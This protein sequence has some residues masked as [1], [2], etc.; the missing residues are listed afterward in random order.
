MLMSLPMVGNG[1][2]LQ[3]DIS[4]NKIRVVNAQDNSND[5]SLQLTVNS[6]NN[7]NAESVLLGGTR[8]LVDGVQNVTTVAESVTIE[9]DNTQVLRNTE[10]IATANK[11]VVVNENAVIDTGV[12]SAKPGEKVLQTNG[13]GALLALSSKNNI[14]Y[15][16]LGGTANAAQG[17][18]IIENGSTLKR[19]FSGGRCNPKREFRWQ[20]GLE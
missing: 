5:G 12:A 13:E 1:D 20:L 10:F 9:N 17:E 11:Q 16:R 14:T 3:V 8:T 15:S 4:S 18:L 6:L 2:G 19:Q 7:L